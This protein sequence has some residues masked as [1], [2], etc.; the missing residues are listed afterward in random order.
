MIF[1]FQDSI[2]KF[3]M[4]E[5]VFLIFQLF[6]FLGQSN[7]GMQKRGQ[8]VIIEEINFSFFDAKNSTPNNGVTITFTVNL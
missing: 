6:H 4:K 3:G 5:E 1:C 8:L 7:A 2:L